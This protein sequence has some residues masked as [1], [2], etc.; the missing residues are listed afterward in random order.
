MTTIAPA[1]GM[2]RMAPNPMAGARHAKNKEGGGEGLRVETIGDIGEVEGRQRVKS[3]WIPIPKG[4]KVGGGGVEGFATGDAR[5]DIVRSF[6]F[7]DSDWIGAVYVDVDWKPLVTDTDVK[8]R[9]VQGSKHR[10]R[11]GD[12]ICFVVQQIP[13]AQIMIAMFGV[14]RMVFAYWLN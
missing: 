2:E 3:S 6:C 13:V 10:N 7:V 4:S 1:V 5:E 8:K 11:S 12:M 14:R 9:T